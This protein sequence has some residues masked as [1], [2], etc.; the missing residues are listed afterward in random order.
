MVARMREGDL[1]LVTSNAVTSLPSDD[2]ELCPVLLTSEYGVRLLPS[3]LL[4]AAGLLFVHPE[5]LKDGANRA[6]WR[7]LFKALGL[8]ESLSVE[9]VQRS[10]SPQDKAQDKW[11][12]SE[13]WGPCPDGEAYEV[14][15][16]HSD[17]LEALLAADLK[18]DERQA[19]VAYLD[20]A[21]DGQ[22]QGY[23][24]MRRSSPTGNTLSTFL[25]H[26]LSAEAADE[27]DAQQW[28]L[29]PTA[30]S[31]LRTLRSQ[32]WLPSRPEGKLLSPRELFP[33]P[34]EDV[35][36]VLGGVAAYI[37]SLDTSLVKPKSP[38][39][40][41]AIQLERPLSHTML[42]DALRCCAGDPSFQEPAST[43]LPLYGVLARCSHDAIHEVKPPPPPPPAPLGPTLGYLIL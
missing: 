34:V 43:L 2:K 30:S 12:A 26:E 23:S 7:S 27:E 1:L 3:S 9:C 5:Y 35:S 15:D 10:I 22:Y 16:W 33:L 40:R 28:H 36:F 17:E 31:F 11:M 21:W 37:P 6:E 18:S 38:S 39:F 4:A 32:P 24:F 20:S 42:L 41:R 19:L 13:D 8:R 25:N 29:L 14:Q